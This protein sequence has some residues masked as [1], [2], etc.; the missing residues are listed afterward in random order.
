MC[1]LVRTCSNGCI[2]PSHEALTCSL[3][4][5]LCAK[6]VPTRMPRYTKG[7]LCG[8][9]GISVYTFAMSANVCRLN[10]VYTFAMSAN[11]CRS[12]KQDNYV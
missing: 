12:N 1:T 5:E 7:V 2:L 8:Q 4:I 9:L 6:A 11:V 10:N 3:C